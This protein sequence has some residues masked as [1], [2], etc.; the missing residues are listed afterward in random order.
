MKLLIV[1]IDGTLCHLKPDSE[2]NKHTGNEKPIENMVYLISSM[3]LL[4]HIKV[5]VM[6]GRKDKFFDITVDWLVS[7]WLP[8]EVIMQK[9]WKA[10]K[11][12][13]FK[14]EQLQKLQEKHEI[15]AVIDD[16]PDMIPVCKELW[17]TMLQVH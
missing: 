11:N 14:K 5:I 3:L 10:G 17:I 15:L 9:K 16:N 12:H 1:D 13:I 8:V 6:T 2:R 7:Q 4:D